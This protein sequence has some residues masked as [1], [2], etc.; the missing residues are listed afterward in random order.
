MDN[1]KHDT[2]KPKMEGEF[3]V[4]PPPSDG[5]SSVKFAPSTNL[6]LAACWDSQLRLYDASTDGRLVHSFT[7][8]H[9]ILDSCFLDNSHAVA[10]GL[11]QKI[12]LYDLNH[13]T[14]TSQ[15]LGTHTKAIRCVEYSPHINTVFSGGWDKKVNAFDPRNSS[16]TPDASIDLPDKVFS[17]SLTESRIVVGTAGRRILCYDIRNLTSPLFDRESSLKYQTRAIRSFPDGEGFAVASIEGRVALEYFDPDCEAKKYSFKCHRVENTVFPV[18][19][20][21]FHPA[22]G[23]FATGGSDGFVNIWD[24]KNKKRL[25]QFPSYPTSVASLCFNHDGSML[26]VAASYSFEEGEKEHPQDNIYI[27]MIGDADVKPKPRAQPNE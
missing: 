3:T 10:A 15:V 23:T 5:I 16:G 21:A 27:R 20:I 26:A 9:P 12:K 6:L 7:S 22:H 18:N 17:M 14:A 11:D 8:T 19:T 25:C 4:N 24:G 13:Q 2:N 1:D